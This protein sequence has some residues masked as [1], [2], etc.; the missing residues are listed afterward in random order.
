MIPNGLQRENFLLRLPSVS[1][2]T[3]IRSGE[4]QGKVGVELCG[5]LQL[6]LTAVSVIPHGSCSCS[7]TSTCEE[8]SSSPSA[9]SRQG[10]YCCGTYS[11]PW[12]VLSASNNGHGPVCA[13]FCLC[14]QASFWQVRVQVLGQS[15]LMGPTRQRPSF[16]HNAPYASNSQGRHRHPQQVEPGSRHSKHCSVPGRVLMCVFSSALAGV[17]AWM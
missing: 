1:H 16:R 11:R 3:K 4:A 15:K 7:S 14:T 17:T 5:E 6:P 10:T 8:Q 12:Y 13:C 2:F 9:T